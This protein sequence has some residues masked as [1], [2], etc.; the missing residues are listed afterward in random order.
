MSGFQKIVLFSAIIILLIV[1][2]IIGIALASAKNNEEWPPLVPDCPDYWAI[3]GLD[4]SGNNMY[5]C[6]NIKDL[7]VC[8]AKDGEK[9]QTM[10]FNTS[11]FTGSNGTCAKSRWAK[12]CKVSW[13][14]ITYGVNDPC[15]TTS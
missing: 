13:D 10:D 15:Q 5:K 8:P 9:H 3:T 7:G 6:V 2:V 4:I 11:M 14:G 12:Q 1:L